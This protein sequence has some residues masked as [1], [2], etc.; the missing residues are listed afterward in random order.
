MTEYWP[1]A[2]TIIITILILGYVHNKQKRTPQSKTIRKATIEEELFIEKVTEEYYANIAV[3]LS[4]GGTA[5]CRYRHK[6]GITDN[7]EVLVQ[8]DILYKNRQLL[9]NCYFSGKC[10]MFFEG[11]TASFYGFNI[12]NVTKGLQELGF[13]NVGFSKS[14]VV[15]NV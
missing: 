2:L 6:I 11:K 3:V 10:D 4:A 9:T 15:V 7:N 14:A 8:I 1:W 13:E 12:D 5:I